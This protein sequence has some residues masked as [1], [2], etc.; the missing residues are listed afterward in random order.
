MNL[1]RNSRTVKETVIQFSVYSFKHFF[2]SLLS[3][4]RLHVASCT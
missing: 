1:K 4:T 3:V 2:L